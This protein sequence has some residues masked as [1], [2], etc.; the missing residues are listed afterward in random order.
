MSK[1][2]I[3][4]K[5]SNH[6]KRLNEYHKRNASNQFAE[7]LMSELSQEEL[8]NLVKILEDHKQKNEGDIKKNGKK[9]QN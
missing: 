3:T 7:K 2:K 1:K 9:I 6:N 4:P 8:A 5:K